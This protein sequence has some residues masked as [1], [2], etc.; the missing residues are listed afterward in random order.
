MYYNV[1]T[2][3]QSGVSAALLL[4]THVSVHRRWIFLYKLSSA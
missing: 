3:E 2:E 4:E 1:V